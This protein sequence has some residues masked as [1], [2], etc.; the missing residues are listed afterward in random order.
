MTSTIDLSRIGWMLS[1]TSR[2]LSKLVDRRLNCVGLTRV[3]WQAIFSLKRIGP[4]TQAA[5]AERMELETATIARLIDRLEAAGWVQR[6]PAARDR[7]VKLVSVTAKAEL[8]MDEVATIGQKVRED[9]LSD[10]PQ[11]ERERFVELLSI[12]KN[13]LTRLLE[14]P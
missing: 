6:E 8:I 5:L 7:R 14:N 1:D 2:L 9:M 12:V 13:R 4:V 10:L 11:Q 3:Q